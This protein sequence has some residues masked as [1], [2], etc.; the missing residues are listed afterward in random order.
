VIRLA[1]VELR[2]FV[3]RRLTQVLVV[4]LL[5]AIAI[6]GV[7]V[8]VNSRAPSAADLARAETWRNENVDACLDRPH[9]Y[10]ADPEPGETQEA[11]CERAAGSVSTY[12]VD[13]RFEL[14]SLRDVFLGTSVVVAALGLVLGASFIGAEWH[15]GT[16]ATLLTWEP[17]RVRVLLVKVAV[18]AAATFVLF[19]AVQAV[20]GLVLGLVAA[21]RGTTEG[22]GTAAWYRSVGGVAVRS[23]ALGAF[24]AAVGLAIATVGRNTAA[25]LGVGFVWFGVVEG[26]VRGLRPGWQ[27]WLV[28]DNAT[29]FLTGTDRGY[30]ALHRTTTSSGLLLLAYAACLGAV[31]VAWFRA[32]DLT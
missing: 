1:G 5:V 19:L 23:A 16:I 27:R 9:R 13:R 18:C 22:T 3:W 2:R 28:G 25:A 31:A 11:A 6:T 26:I 20:L 29:T 14:S 30:P 15:W 10:G 4:L 32:R 24:A 12:V 7:I 17:R 21:T 8:A